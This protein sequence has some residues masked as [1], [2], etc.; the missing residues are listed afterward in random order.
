[1]NK[2]FDETSMGITMVVRDF[3]NEYGAIMSDCTT[4]KDL[5]DLCTTIRNEWNKGQQC[6]IEFFSI[7]YLADRY[8]TRF[9]N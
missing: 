3:Y 1:M 6:T 8:L 5:F 4:D 9:L 2:Q 7:K